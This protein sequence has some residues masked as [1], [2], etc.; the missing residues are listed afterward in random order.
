MSENSSRIIFRDDN[1]ELRWFDARKTLDDWPSGTLTLSLQGTRSFQPTLSLLPNGTWVI[2]PNPPPYPP[3]VDVQFLSDS[4]AVDWI[5]ERGFDLPSCLKPALDAKGFTASPFI[6]DDP[7]ANQPR[8]NGLRDELVKVTPGGEPPSDKSGPAAVD[9]RTDDE[10]KATNV[11]ADAQQLS[12]K[13]Q[14][15]VL[16]QLSPAKRKAY[17]S[18]QYAES[19]AGKKL[20]DNEAWKLLKDQGLSDDADDLGELTDYRIPA[21]DT[22]SRQLRK[23]RNALGEQKYTPR[24]GRRSG[25]SIVK[26]NEIEFQHGDD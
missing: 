13:Q 18:Y 22:W 15:V 19:K 8:T 11:G 26:G 1:G 25:S 20:Q 12:P 14:K 5:L 9:E 23:A 2:W 17:F 6:V 10:G 3:P 16:K 24:G 21:F 4:E 7:I